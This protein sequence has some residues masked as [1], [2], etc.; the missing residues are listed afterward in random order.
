MDSGGLKIYFE[1]HL[2]N[3][4][5]TKVCFCPLGLYIGLGFDTN[6]NTQQTR[7]AHSCSLLI[8]PVT[9]DTPT[10][11]PRAAL[12][13]VWGPAWT[14]QSPSLRRDQSHAGEG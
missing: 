3:I 13:P 5:N 12:G 7:P 14:Y 4:T 2:R 8:Q 10:H 11:S 6:S 1:E 9:S